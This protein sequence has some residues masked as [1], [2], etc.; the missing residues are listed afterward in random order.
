MSSILI[1]ED[2]KDFREAVKDFILTKGIKAD[3]LLAMTG[4]QGVDI[5]IRKQPEV[6]IMDIHLG[7]GMNGLEAAAIIKRQA[8]SCGIIILTMFAMGGVKDL[9]NKEIVSDFIDKSD[10]DTRLIPA[11]NRLLHV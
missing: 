3:I 11:V 7:I 4:E 1:V 10:L 8:A 2:H 5:A 9:C 6:V